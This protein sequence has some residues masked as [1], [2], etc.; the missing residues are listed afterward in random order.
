MFDLSSFRKD[1]LGGRLLKIKEELW[2]RAYNTHRTKKE[3]FKNLKGEE[4]YKALGELH[5]IYSG[6]HS[7]TDKY[8]IFGQ[9]QD[10]LNT[11]YYSTI[12]HLGGRLHMSRISGTKFFQATGSNPM[13]WWGANYR[14]HLA[15]GCEEIYLW[16]M[17]DQERL[18]RGYI[19]IYTVIR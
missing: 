16:T 3:E 15:M 8:H 18:V 12:A 6:L 1:F 5:K 17:E 19:E 10:F 2:S 7:F 14:G 9:S 4:Y 11:I 13:T